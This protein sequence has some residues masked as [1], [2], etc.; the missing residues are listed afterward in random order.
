MAATTSRVRGW[1][2]RLRELQLPC[3]CWACLRKAGIT[4]HR[5]APA[6]YRTDVTGRMHRSDTGRCV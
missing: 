1:E 2:R 5:G 3:T 6:P 4:P